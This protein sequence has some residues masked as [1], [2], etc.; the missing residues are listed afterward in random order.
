MRERVL[1]NTKDGAFGEAWALACSLGVS[2][3]EPARPP[4]GPKKPKGKA[5]PPRK[6]YWT[7]LAA[8]G[9]Q[10]R[11][12]RGARWEAWRWWRRR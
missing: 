8:D 3:K 11:V 1:K 6:C 12:G 5:P 10:I 9:T 7:Y 4:R 2:D